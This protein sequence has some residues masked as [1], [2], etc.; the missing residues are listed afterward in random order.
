MHRFQSVSAVNQ[1]QMKLLKVIYNLKNMMIQEFQHFAEFQLI[2]VMSFWKNGAVQIDHISRGTKADDP[3]R[4]GK[5]WKNGEEIS[6]SLTHHF[7]TELFWRHDSDSDPVI[8]IDF[9]IEE[10]TR[11][12]I[13]QAACNQAPCDSLVI[14]GCHWRCF[15]VYHT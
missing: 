8:D 6:I 9:C 4:M 12:T 1:V 13:G 14:S 15:R 5:L 10:F 11:S 2:Q 3:V 7:G